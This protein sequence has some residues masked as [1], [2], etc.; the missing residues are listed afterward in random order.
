MKKGYE[1]I[2]QKY[3]LEDWLFY[4]KSKIISLRSFLK[5]IK[6][7]YHKIIKFWK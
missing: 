2:E 1:F 4:N 7:Y 5:L 3:I 6:T